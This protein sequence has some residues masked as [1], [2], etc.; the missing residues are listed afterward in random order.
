MVHRQETWPRLGEKRSGGNGSFSHKRLENWIVL[1]RCECGCAEGLDVERECRA[2]I[3]KRR[4]VSVPLADD[5]TPRKAKRISDVA[6]G[7]LLD[8]DLQLW[9]HVWRMPR[10]LESGKS[11]K[12]PSAKSPRLYGCPPWERSAD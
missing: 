11:A 12:S 6:I 8:D 5:H 2:D 9:C 10:E 1:G 4:L 3:R 7:M